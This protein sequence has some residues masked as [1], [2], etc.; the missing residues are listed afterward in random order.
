MT[1]IRTLVLLLMVCL[2][3]TPP[4]GN[5]VDLDNATWTNTI[6]DPS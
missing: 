5:T 2:L 3:M 6:G 1:E 4:V